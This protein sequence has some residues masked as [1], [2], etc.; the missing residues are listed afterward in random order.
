MSGGLL[1]VEFNFTWKLTGLFPKNGTGVGMF[2]F[3]I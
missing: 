2:I 3:Y 1:K